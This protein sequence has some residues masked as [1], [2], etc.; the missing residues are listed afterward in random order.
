MKL[1]T[2]KL[3][4]KL[5]LLLTFFF[6]IG[7]AHS[8]I[9]IV[10]LE[11]GGDVVFSYSG[12]IDTTGASLAGGQALSAYSGIIPNLGIVGNS[13]TPYDGYAITGG[14]TFGTGVNT[15]ATISTGDSFQIRSS[16]LRVRLPD[17]YVSGT[18]ISGTTISGDI[19]FT[20]TDFTTL[21]VDSSSNITWNLPND[22]ISL[23]FTAI[24]EPSS[25][26]LLGLGGL[27]FALRRRR[28]C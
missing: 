14:G 22:S 18:T 8:A 19:T 4:N 24:P 28:S 10:A 13:G 6:G 12:T 5:A 17:N 23:Q 27:A 1:K 11:T 7:A 2:I 3:K 25:T 20:G 21:G 26:A 15:V 16:D 9:V